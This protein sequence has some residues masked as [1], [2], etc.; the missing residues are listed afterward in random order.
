[1]TI[2]LKNNTVTESVLLDRIPQFDERSRQ[3]PLTAV[4]PTVTPRSYTWRCNEWFDQGQDGACHKEGTEV[5]TE[6][7]WVDFREVVEDDLLGTVNQLTH[8]IEFQKPKALQRLDFEGELLTSNNRNVAFSVTPDHRM[9]VRKWVEKNRTLSDKYEFVKAEDLGWYSG[10]LSAPSQRAN[11]KLFESIQIGEGKRGRLI[12]GDDLISFLGIFLAEGCLYHPKD[13]GSYRIE[14]A[15]VKEGCRDEVYDIVSRLGFNVTT[16]HDRYTIHSKPLFDFLKDCYQNGALTKKIP[17]WMFSISP[18]QCE[19][20]LHS[21]CLGD[22]HTTKDGRRFF[23][24]SSKSLADGIQVLFL[25]LGIRTNVLER[26]PRD[27]WIDGRMI[28]K[29]SCEMAYVVSPWKKTSLSIEKKNQITTEYYKGKVYCATVE[30]STLI[31]RYGGTVLISGNCVAYALG[32]ELASRPAETRGMNDTW[33][34]ESVYWEAQKIDPWEGG[35]YPGADT[36]YEGTSI[37]AGVK[38]LKDKGF[39]KEYRWAFSIDEVILGLGRNGPAVLGLPWY[40]GMFEPDS[41]GYIQKTG[42][43][44]GGHAITAR[45]VNLKTETI[46]LRNSWGKNWGKDGDCYI[47]FHELESLLKEWGEAVFLVGRTKTP[48]VPYTF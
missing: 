5:L 47:K 35:S 33:L 40:E 37:L 10:L 26:E 48:M 7:G 39:F 36:F 20:F 45:G 31:T 18:R 22:G 44:M 16:Y 23:Y 2:K 28:K 29:E 34:K 11:S 15:A 24:T 6:R 12:N 42:R 46:T 32:H 30:N 41:K 3:F 4:L 9:W 19:L 14:I 21:F 1:M 27:S 17:E 38:I 43:I 13:S 8:E 25:N